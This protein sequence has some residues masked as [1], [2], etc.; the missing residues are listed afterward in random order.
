MLTETAVAFSWLDIGAGLP[1][2]PPDLTKLTQANQELKK[3][4]T[5][6]TRIKM[7]RR[8]GA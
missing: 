3:E 8:A 1:E 7:R 2:W 4:P 5:L 6:L